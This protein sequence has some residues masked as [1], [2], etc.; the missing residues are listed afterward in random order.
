MV[1]LDWARGDVVPGATKVPNAAVKAKI[2]YQLGQ[3]LQ[4]KWKEM[5]SK[6]KSGTMSSYEAQIAFEFDF[7]HGGRIFQINDQMLSFARQP[8]EP[9]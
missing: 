3:H 7:G 5:W 9:N 8:L 1:R 4:I 2:L 6:V